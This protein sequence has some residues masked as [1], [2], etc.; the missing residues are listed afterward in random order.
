MTP[1]QSN[2]LKTLKEHPNMT[3]EKL[4]EA[5]GM[6]STSHAHYHIQRLIKMGLLEKGKRWVVKDAGNI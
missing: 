5:V 3:M 4:C 6:G 2:I 1:I